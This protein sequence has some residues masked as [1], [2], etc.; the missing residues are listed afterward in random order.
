MELSLPCS[1]GAYSPRPAL[2]SLRDS[3]C[4]THGSL[5]AS[6]V[7]LTAV[8]TATL[9]ELLGQPAGPSLARVLQHLISFTGP[10]GI[11]HQ[12]LQAGEGWRQAEEDLQLLYDHTLY[13]AAAAGPGSAVWSQVVEALQNAT[14]VR[15]Q[16]DTAGGSG[17]RLLFVKPQQLCFNLDAPRVSCYPVPKITTKLTAPQYRQL[18]LAQGALDGDLPNTEKPSCQPIS[19]EARFTA[20]CQ[21]AFLDALPSLFDSSVWSDLTVIVG[22]EHILLHRIVIAP[23]SEPLAAMWRGP[24]PKPKPSQADCQ[25]GWNAIS[26]VSS[27]RQ[28]HT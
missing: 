16:Q 25:P 2:V 1:I 5:L 13:A 8:A 6:Q 15:V 10:H 28:P 18:M 20:P 23:H 11:A 26:C 22:G 24:P 17:Q 4:C 3:E 27:T 21:K 14:Y 9:R 7:P 19:T 12:R